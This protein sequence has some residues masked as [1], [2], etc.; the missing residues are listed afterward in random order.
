MHTQGVGRQPQDSP[1]LRLAE[2][3]GEEFK[4]IHVKVHQRQRAALLP[5]SG[6]GPARRLI[7]P[8]RTPNPRKGVRLSLAPGR[9]RPFTEE[10]GGEP[11]DKVE[12]EIQLVRPPS[13]PDVVQRPA[14]R[15]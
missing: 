9:T 6:H 7:K 12:A 2:T 8:P 3:L 11:D 15:P 13:P 5:G 1:S 14:S 4:V 10:G